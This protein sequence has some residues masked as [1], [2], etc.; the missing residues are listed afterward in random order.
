MV[1]QDGVES[2]IK[3]FVLSEFLEGEDPAALQATTDLI[4][5]G[6]VDSLATLKLIAFVED[7]FGVSIAAHEADAH[8]FSTIAGI[9]DL[10]CSKL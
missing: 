7:R 4:G 6:I 8:T 9:R 1:N 10:V 5:T 3:D 2:T